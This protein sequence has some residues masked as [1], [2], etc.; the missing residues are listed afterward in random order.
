MD[1]L[2]MFETDDFAETKVNAKYVNV[3]LNFVI[4]REALEKALEEQD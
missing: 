4:T 3:S 2:V 1:D